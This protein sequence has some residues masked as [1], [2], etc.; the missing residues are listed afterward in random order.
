[1]KQTV[2]NYWSKFMEMNII[3]AYLLA[4]V[5]HFVWTVFIGVI[6]LAFGAEFSQHVASDSAFTNSLFLIPCCAIAEEMLFRWGPFLLLFTI[7][8]VIAK[9][10]T[11][12]EKT[13]LY[14]ILSVVAV[15]SVIFGYVHGNVFNILIQGVS[16][17][18]FCMFYFRTLIKNKE[19]GK[20]DKYQLRPLMSSSC[21]H[22][23]VNSVLI[24]L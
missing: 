5:F 3:K 24:F 10:V 12:S 13:K 17:V 23:F 19:A 20:K 4:L 11:I 16:G 7:L 9:F 1:M 22:T 6:L 2:L 8:G 15:S 21:Y 18:V 14:A